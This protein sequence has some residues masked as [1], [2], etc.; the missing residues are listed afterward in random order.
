LIYS[1]QSS[2]PSGC[3]SQSSTKLGT[4]SQRHSTASGAPSDSFKY[5]RKRKAE[6]AFSEIWNQYQKQKIQQIEEKKEIKAQN[7]LK[8]EKKEIEKMKMKEEY[9]KNK[10]SLSQQKNSILEKLAQQLSKSTSHSSSRR[11]T[12][13]GQSS[14]SSSEES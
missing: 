12:L 7:E 4:S 14:D 2:S 11:S 3:S 6:D 5:S 8:K 1:P 10:L 13:V 9:Y